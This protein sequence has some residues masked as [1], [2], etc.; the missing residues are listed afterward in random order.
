MLNYTHRLLQRQT[1]GVSLFRSR[2]INAAISPPVII[3]PSSSLARPSPS[4]LEN[5]GPRS[6][7]PVS[8]VVVV[9]C[10]QIIDC[11]RLLINTSI[12]HTINAHP[13]DP[14]V[15]VMAWIYFPA[16]KTLRTTKTIRRRPLPRWWQWRRVFW[17]WVN[18]TFEHCGRRESTGLDYIAELLKSDWPANLRARNK[19]DV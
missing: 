16:E 12:S 13:P 1:H 14:L 5:R 7:R 6:T 3:L 19:G 8:C 17:S 18:G 9:H 10:T 15:D 11:A 4:A 2:A